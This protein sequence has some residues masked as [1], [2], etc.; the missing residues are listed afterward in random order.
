MFNL[1]YLIGFLGGNFLDTAEIAP[2]H[3]RVAMSSISTANHWLWNFIITMITPVALSSIGWKYY[4]VFA[5]LSASVPVIVIPFFPGDDESQPR[6][7]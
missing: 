6:T 5:V 4:I 3:L 1:C 2:V 7:D